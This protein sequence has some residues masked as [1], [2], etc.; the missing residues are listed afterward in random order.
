MATHGILSGPP[1]SVPHADAY[2]A[3]AEHAREQ[4]SQ[5]QRSLH[6]CA[7]ILSAAALLAM[8]PLWAP[9]LLAVW[10]AI[11]AR[12]LH[13]RL[14]RS[15][16][17][18]SRGAAVVTVA[19]VIVAL[20][21]IAVIGL[22]LFA[23][24]L[25]LIQRMQQS[26]GIRE[27]LQSLLAAEPTLSRQNWDVQQ[28][29]ELAR[30]HG[31]DALSA[32]SKIFGAA[33]AGAVGLFIFVYGFYVCLVDGQSAYNWLREHSP[34]RP[35]QLDRLAAAFVETGRGLLL[36]VGLTALFQ[37]AVA[38][39]G[40]LIIG[41]PQGLVLGLLTAFAA[42]IPSIGTGLVWVPIAIGLFAAG[43]TKSGIAMLVLGAVI[44]VA[45]NVVRPLFSRSAHLN[46]PAFVLLVAM[47][48]GIAIYGG[49]GL[50]C[51]PL[52]VRLAVEALRLYREERLGLTIS[53]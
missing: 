25:N 33:A 52:F 11:L 37:G 50:L 9:L 39:V 12:P 27:S 17:G 5:E 31:M 47:L 46:L 21:P 53:S 45:D 43:R 30:R 29:I 40:Y 13:A 19:L 14:G 34:L 24:A 51:A 2:P 6:W 42:L 8:F 35:A 28:M 41:V 48:G 26:G 1:P 38:T 10:M 20:A 16:A 36:G 3:P 7:L 4:R 49:W 44:S 18:R 22:S 15:K 32:A 23:A